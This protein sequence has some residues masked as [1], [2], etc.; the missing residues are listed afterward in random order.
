M[1]GLV[2]HMTDD[3]L[4]E[5]LGISRVIKRYLLHTWVGVWEQCTVSARDG[6]ACEAKFR[7]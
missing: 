3:V 2:N 6:A 4:Q 1:K 7:V 5:I